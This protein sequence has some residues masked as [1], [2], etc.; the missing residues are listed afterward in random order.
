MD[1]QCCEERYNEDDNQDEHENMPKDTE[2]APL[3]KEIEQEA[4]QDEEKR[5]KEKDK[6]TSR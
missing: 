4:C 1:L 5:N 3:K 2:D 6:K